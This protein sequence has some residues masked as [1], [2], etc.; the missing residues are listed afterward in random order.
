MS[1]TI[2]STADAIGQS[3]E[4]ER[5]KGRCRRTHDNRSPMRLLTVVRGISKISYERFRKRR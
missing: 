2:G 1:G 4:S 3:L 5:G